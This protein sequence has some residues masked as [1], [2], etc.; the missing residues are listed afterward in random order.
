M[1]EFHNDCIAKPEEGRPSLQQ[2]RSGPAPPHSM[3]GANT[4]DHS[5]V[6]LVSG[7]M[8]VVIPGEGYCCRVFHC[9]L[10][11]FQL[12]RLEK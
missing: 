9:I 1:G 12:V 4:G 7:S 11:G 10:C 2:T 5:R 3:F 8:L 6:L